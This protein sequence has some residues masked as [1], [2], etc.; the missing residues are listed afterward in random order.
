MELTEVQEK[1]WGYVKSDL[2]E[3]PVASTDHIERMTTWCQQLRLEAGAD[4][5]VLVAGALLHDV[6]VVINRKRH[7]VVGRAR[8]AEIL[9]EVRFPRLSSLN[10][11]KSGRYVSHRKGRRTWSVKD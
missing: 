2:A 1:I 5:E 8:A 7:Y 10:P 6:G 4:V 3:E 9:K 11:G